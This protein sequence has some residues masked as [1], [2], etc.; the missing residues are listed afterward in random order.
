MK[1][2][3]LL[4]LY[5]EEY[6]R[7]YTDL[8]LVGEHFRECTE[9]EIDV[10][11]SFVEDGKTWLDAACGTG[12]ILSQ[13]PEV[14]RA[15]FDLSPSMLAEAR[16]RNSDI[17][18]FL[19][20]LRNERPEWEGKWDV[21]SC[22]WFAYCYADTV[23]QISTILKNFA[24]W[25]R[26]GGVLFLPVCEPNVLTKLSVPHNPPADSDDGLLFIDAV[27]WTWVDQPSGRVHKN[28]VAPTLETLAGFLNKAFT[29]VT[30][31]PYPHFKA[32][33]LAS[34]AAFIAVK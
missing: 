10:L 31:T 23:D 2:T 21:I 7:G 11:K 24:S 16:K 14:H 13:F 3:E 12:Y 5:D 30:L 27:I 25:L 18:L 8:C 29:S 19:H 15:G 33:C 26:P 9:H 32:D 6:A 17:E 1:A 20:D 4:S 34:R 22:M 28:L